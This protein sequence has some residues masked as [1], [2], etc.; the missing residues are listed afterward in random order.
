MSRHKGQRDAAS[1]V[2]LIVVSLGKF[3]LRKLMPFRFR[4]ATRS[5]IDLISNSYHRP[6]CQADRRTVTA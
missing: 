3:H 5:F 2:A 1:E 6:L 4:S